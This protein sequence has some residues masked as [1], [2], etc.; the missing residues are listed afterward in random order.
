MKSNNSCVSFRIL[1][2]SLKK[3]PCKILEHILADVEFYISKVYL[4][5]YYFCIIQSPWLPTFKSLHLQVNQ[6]QLLRCF[7]ILRL[8]HRGKDKV[9]LWFLLT[10]N[11]SLY[12]KQKIPLSSPP[13]TPLNCLFCFILS[14]PCLHE[15]LQN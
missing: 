12:E 5:S 15:T 7:G 4:F 11:Y 9:K 6:S 3:N 1:H 13:L 2:S 8:L 14:D 10:S